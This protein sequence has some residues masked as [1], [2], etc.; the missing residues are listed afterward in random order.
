M[1]Y[2]EVYAARSMSAWI[3]ATTTTTKD[4]QANKPIKMSDTVYGI[5]VNQQNGL[6]L[7]YITIDRSNQI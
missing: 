3:N 4:I 6:N 7:N 2:S 5:L 1:W